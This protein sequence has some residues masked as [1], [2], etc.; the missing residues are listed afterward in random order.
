MVLGVPILQHFRVAWMYINPKE[1]TINM[2]FMTS[3]W[4]TK[5]IAE[6]LQ[7]S[8]LSRPIFSLF[9]CLCKQL[10]LHFCLLVH[11]SQGRSFS[12]FK[13]WKI[14]Q[15][16][17]LTCS[18][19]IYLW[20]VG[21]FSFQLLNFIIWVKPSKTNII[22]IDVLLTCIP[23]PWCYM[24]VPKCYYKCGHMMFMSP[25]YPMNNSNIIW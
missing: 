1:Q 2:T 18:K 5:C 8:F 11:V 17:I 9:Y 10:L 7:L 13:F 19:T 14:L 12:N 6:K 23:C 25:L 15:Y 4:Q 3:S 22:S 16:P 20:L 24:Y 21:V